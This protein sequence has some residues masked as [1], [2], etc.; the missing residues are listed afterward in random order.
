MAGVRFTTPATVVVAGETVLL[1][2]V[3]ISAVAAWSE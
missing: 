2:S 1:G 3:V